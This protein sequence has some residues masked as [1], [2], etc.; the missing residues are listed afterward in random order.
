MKIYG[1]KPVVPQWC[2]GRKFLPQSS[3]NRPLWYLDSDALTRSRNNNL[4]EE[5]KAL[6]RGEWGKLG[7][8]RYSGTLRDRTGLR[9]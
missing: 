4:G 5:V 1:N 9:L 8:W 7:E 2:G 6:L 3:S